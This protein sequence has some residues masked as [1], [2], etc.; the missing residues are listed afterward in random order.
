MRVVIVDDYPVVREEIR[1][2]L[3]NEP[4]IQVVG[5]AA[6]GE[7][8]LEVVQETGPS[9]LILDLGLPDMPGIK[10]ARLL[11]QRWPELRILVLSGHDVAQYGRA[12]ARMGIQGYLSKDASQETLVE[13]LRKIDAGGVVLPASTSRL[14]RS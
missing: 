12:F 2:I 14:K 5:E 8:A 11:R 10:A 6:T 13:A 1:R 9:V 3:D 7:E 4:D